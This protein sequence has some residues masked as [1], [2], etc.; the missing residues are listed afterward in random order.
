MSNAL[1]KFIKTHLNSLCLCQMCFNR[2]Q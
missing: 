1:L 2:L